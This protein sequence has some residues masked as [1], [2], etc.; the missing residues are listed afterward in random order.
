MPAW[1]SVGDKQADSIHFEGKRQGKRLREDGAAFSWQT[2]QCVLFP[3]LA[4]FF[5]PQTTPV[6]LL[7]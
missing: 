2:A 4:E 1:S 3:T 6:T 7:L 5:F